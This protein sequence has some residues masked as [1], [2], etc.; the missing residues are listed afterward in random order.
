MQ[1]GTKSV[2]HDEHNDNNQYLKW[3]YG[4]VFNWG[5]RPKGTWSLTIRNSPPRGVGI[6][7]QLNAELYFWRLR[8]FGFEVPQSN[9]TNPA[10]PP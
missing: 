1:L 4:S 10:P 8:L 7:T 6:N 9:G 3:N 5:E 2:L